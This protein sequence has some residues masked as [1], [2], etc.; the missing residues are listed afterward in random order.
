MY[1]G[2]IMDTE[3]EV[4]ILSECVLKSHMVLLNMM[5]MKSMT[6]RE[7][8]G[9][10]DESKIKTENS[11][12]RNEMLSRQVENERNSSDRNE[13]LSRQVENERDSTQTDMRC[14]PDRL[15]MRNEDARPQQA[16]GSHNDGKER[17][18]EV[19][20]Q[21]LANAQEQKVKADEV[22]KVEAARV[23]R[24]KIKL[25]KRKAARHVSPNEDSESGSE[26][27]RKRTRRVN[28]QGDRRQRWGGR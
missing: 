22:K 7:K 12:D 1:T 16:E 13:M 4:R 27:A 17:K 14:P 24:T 9:F 23:A 18:H 10:S 11:S 25:V 28:R 6:Y 20:A 26:S 21:P 2:E 19:D 3:A 8:G 15:R 5:Q